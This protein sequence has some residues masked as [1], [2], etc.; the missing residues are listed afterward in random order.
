MG[1]LKKIG[2]GIKTFT[3]NR[4][5]ELKDVAGAVCDVVGSAGKGVAT[6]VTDPKQFAEDVANNVKGWG[7]NL[8]EGWMNGWEDF[9]EGAECIKEGGIK[10]LLPGLGKMVGGATYGITGGGFGAGE[11]IKDIAEENTIVNRDEMGNVISIEIKEDAKGVGRLIANLNNDKSDVDRINRKE[12]ID[13][14]IAEGDFDRANRVIGQHVVNVGGK[15]VATTAAVAGI[16][17]MPF[18]AG[19]SGWVTAAVLGGVGVTGAASGIASTYAGAKFD[20]ENLSDDVKD[21][22][23]SEVE[24]LMADGSLTEE[25]RATYEE[26]LS[27]YL[28]SASYLATGV[29]DRETF[30]YVV[31]ANHLLNKPDGSHINPDELTATMDAFIQTYAPMV[32]SGQITQDQANRLASLGANYALT[33]SM[34]DTTYYANMY[35]IQTENLDMTPEQN[36]AYVAHMVNYALGEYDDI[37]LQQA[38]FTDPVLQDFVQPDGTMFI[39]PKE[40]NNSLYA[41]VA[42]QETAVTATASGPNAGIENMIETSYVANDVENDIEIASNDEIFA[43]MGI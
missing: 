29:S 11:A 13:E 12:E 1:F 15:V 16:V 26:Y 36:N 20:E 32:E 39:P 43:A 25:N 23:S 14:A 41:S 17:A 3:K 37:Q 34:D 24:S 8:K 28:N 38:I 31:N 18:T 33:G 2:N 10:G 19:Q 7:E 27:Q 5:E 9:G 6:L 40:N 21:A 35:M 30:D 42:Q 4:V 22:I